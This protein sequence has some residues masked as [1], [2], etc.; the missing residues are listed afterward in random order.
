MHMLRKTVRI[1]TLGLQA[2]GTQN[3]PLSARAVGAG[4]CGGGKR[5]AAVR[6]RARRRG[7]VM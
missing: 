5:G 2:Q 7:P 4:P 1:L 6:R 3:T